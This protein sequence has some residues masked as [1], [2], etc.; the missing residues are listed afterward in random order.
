MNTLSNHDWEQLSAY[1]DG[2]LDEAACEL[3]MLRLQ[4]EPELQA[5]LARMQRAHKEIIEA[6]NAVHAQSATTQPKLR[7]VADATRSQAAAAPRAG[8]PHAQPRVTPMH[9]SSGA[10]P[11]ATLSRSGLA[12]A[13]SV[14]ALS[15]M[16]I[17]NLGNREAAPSG[18]LA[19][20]LSAA[21][22]AT[23]S[24]H[25]WH[26]VDPDTMLRPVLSFPARDGRWCREYQL[27]DNNGA[28]RGIACKEK[29]GWHAEVVVADT[30]S[31]TD[32]DYTPAGASDPDALARFAAEQAADIPAGREQEKAL[33]AT[34]WFQ[35]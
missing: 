7:L 9:R 25:E 8:L 32:E 11:A 12:L 15:S 31:T 14:V 19:P 20:S 29:A 1:L 28:W 17:L 26:P 16:L 24:G 27:T 18:R 23:P 2:E 10:R 21:L 3:L 5:V 30:A 33:I 6:V 35:P 34:G 4:R 22:D 13:A